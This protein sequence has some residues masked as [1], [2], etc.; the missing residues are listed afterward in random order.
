MDER[1][2]KGDEKKEF[3]SNFV[4]HKNCLDTR[5][6]TTA[7]ETHA[8]DTHQIT[9]TTTTTEGINA[10]TRENENGTTQTQDIPIMTVTVGTTIEDTTVMIEMITTHH[11]AET[12]AQETAAA[13]PFNQ[14]IIFKKTK[15]SIKG[16]E[17]EVKIKKLFLK[18]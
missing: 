5:K 16:Q 14:E 12:V 9:T 3:C 2:K 13:E 18:S 17:A 11:I 1:N 15:I 7:K 4:F 8:A 10:E 6:I